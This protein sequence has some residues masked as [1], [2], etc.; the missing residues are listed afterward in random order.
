M[1]LSNISAMAISIPLEHLPEKINE[2]QALRFEIEA[3]HPTL[4][5]GVRIIARLLKEDQPN[6]TFAQVDGLINLFM[7]QMHKLRDGKKNPYAW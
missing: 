5:N 6:Q 3:I 2:I 1:N 4:E 7:E